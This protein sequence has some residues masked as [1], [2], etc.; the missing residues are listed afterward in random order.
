MKRIEIQME[1]KRYLMMVR[2]RRRMAT[3]GR[4]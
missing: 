4:T 3:I 1:A 2:N